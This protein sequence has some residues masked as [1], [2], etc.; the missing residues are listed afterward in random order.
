M[1]FA[2]K[3]TS[4]QNE[5]VYLVRGKD[6]GEAAWHYILIKNKATLPLF[7]KAID[8]DSVDIATFGKI[9]HS[10]WGENPPEEVVEDIKKRFG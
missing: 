6:K 3:V 7:L 5:L 1:S 9:L 2:A 10:G 4:S 8:T